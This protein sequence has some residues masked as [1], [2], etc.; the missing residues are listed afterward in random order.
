VD[1][2]SDSVG[3]YP[4]SD[5]GLYLNEQIREDF[6]GGAAML[7]DDEQGMFETTSQNVADAVSTLITDGP[8][9]AL[10]YAAM[11]SEISTAITTPGF[12][13]TEEPDA[14]EFRGYWNLMWRLQEK[15]FFELDLQKV[16]ES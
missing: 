13:G 9:P 11:M 16:T 1:Y 15:A 12:W 10:I 2:T 4:R 3:N 8:H 7:N 14:F 5:F 6:G